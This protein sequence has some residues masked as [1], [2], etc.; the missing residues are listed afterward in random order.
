MTRLSTLFLPTL[1]EAPADAE[2]ISHK[3]M[4]RAGLIRQLGAGMWTYLPAGWR[5][6][7]NVEQIIREEID[8]I[9]GQEM[10]M[11]VLQPA[12]PWRESGRYAIPELFK[13]HDRKEAELVLAMT[14]EEAVT[15][16]VARE[17]RSYR[18]LPMILYHLQTKE[19]DE[20]RPRAGVLRTREFTMK[21]SYSFDRDID[22]LDASYELH[23]GAYDRILDRCGLRWYRVDSDV[24]M[25]GGLG[26]HEYMAPCP[27][28]EN[29]VALA[30][31]YAANV[32]IA[33]ADPQPVELP[34]GLDEPKRVETPG[35]TTVEE[36]SAALEAPPGA[37]LK[38]IPVVVEG[39]GFVLTLVRGDHR[40]N[41]I[42]LRN[43][44][45]AVF[46]QARPEEIEAELGPPGFI[47]PVRASVPVLK[48]AAI[49]GE[50]YFGGAN[51][52]G[53]HLTGIAPGR[54]FEF[55]E[56]DI[57]SVEAGDRSPGGHEIRIEPAIEVGNIFKLGT[58]YSEPMGATYLD[59]DGAER[60][61]VMGSY[62][63]GP[64]RIVAAAIEQRADE[65]GIVWPRAIA[66]WQI[67][68]VALGKP[69]DD[70]V[71]AADR[72]YE[73]L[74]FA[75]VEVLYDDREA[76]A[77]EKLTDA[78]LLGCPV[79]LTVGPRALAEGEIEAQTRVI[80]VDERLAVDGAAGAAA[81]L[82]ERA[83]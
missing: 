41:E 9:G 23:I 21:D 61:I 36:V 74:R 64:A 46:R 83:R 32:E 53:L 62:G 24:G 12:G 72:L 19:R 30:D 69:G 14:H 15:W 52:P 59:E 45:G 67:H 57:R 5:A 49:Q 73:E 77:G 48:D 75:G 65:R 38:G 17:V 71:A 80:G 10:L 54:D 47:G 16:H 79:R 44:L 60:P 42:K 56:V 50:G 43:A 2:A 58:R 40:L 8:A 7:A 68:L 20:P 35:L 26:A 3:L 28:G 29:E 34:P 18:E 4:V 11:P 66:P 27:A 6:H 33:A 39:R 31:D 51:E 82:L 37:A 63:I 81:E 55:E 1:K 22:G 13:L 25:M 70:T 78:E 76:G